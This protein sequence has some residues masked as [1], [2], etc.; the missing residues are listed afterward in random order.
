RAR[1]RTFTLVELTRTLEAI[2]AGK[3]SVRPDPVGDGTLTGFL[4]SAVEAAGV[5]RIQPLGRGG[6]FDIEDPFRRR[7]AVYR[8]SAD[9]VAQNVDRML[10]ALGSLAEQ[11]VVAAAGEASAPPA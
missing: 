11:P 7:T 6:G 3:A 1:R 10:A 5:C 9:A 2:V 4:R 8:R